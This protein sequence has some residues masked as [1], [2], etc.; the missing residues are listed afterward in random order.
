MSWYN[1]ENVEQKHEIKKKGLV[2]E[3]RPIVNAKEEEK[4]INFK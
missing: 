4:K 1:V 3:R 2:W